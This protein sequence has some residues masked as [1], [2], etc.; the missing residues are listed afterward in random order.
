MALDRETA[1]QVA[2]VLSRGLPYIQRFTGK[3]VVIKYGGNAMENEF[4]PRCGAD[5]TCRHQPDRCPWR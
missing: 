2:S 3:T 5:E 4:C 1:M